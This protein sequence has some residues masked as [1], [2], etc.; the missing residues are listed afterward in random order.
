MEIEIII[1]QFNNK[2]LIVRFCNRILY[3]KNILSL[4]CYTKTKY[5][6]LL[7]Y[8]KKHQYRIFLSEILY[9]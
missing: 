4:S 2:F 9:K 7:Y 6:I 8:L 5:T 3:R 1:Y